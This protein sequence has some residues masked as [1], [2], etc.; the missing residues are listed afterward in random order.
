MNIDYSGIFNPWSDVLSI[1][2]LIVLLLSLTYFLSERP[3]TKYQYLRKDF[4]MSQPE[5]D[6]FEVLLASVEN[7]YHVFP[8]VHLD[9]ILNHKIRGQNWFGAFRHINEKSVDFVICDKTYIKPLL[10]IELD[11]R[12]H[13]REDRIERD[14][15]VERI[16]NEAGMPL[17]RFKHNEHFETE[18][19]KRLVSE[20]L[21]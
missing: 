20:K 14:E 9:V 13:E 4:V 2:L 15:E 10:A 16:L 21:N 5:R 11:D 6:F 12:S 3:V 8:Q 1:G 7:Q 17:L 19:I 18:E